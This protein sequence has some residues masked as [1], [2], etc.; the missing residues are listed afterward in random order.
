M[1]G[2]RDQH[3]GCVG[4][5]LVE[6]DLFDFLLLSL[7]DN[8]T[9]SHKHGPHAQVTSIADADR[10]LERVMH[11]GGGP[12][13]FLDE[14]AV[15]VVADHSH[16]PVERASRP[17]RRV[18]RL[19]GAAGPRPARAPTT[20]RSRVC[21]SQRAAMVYV[22]VPERARRSVLPRLRRRRRSTLEGVDLVMRRERATR[23]SSRA[24]RGE[25][26][27]APGRA[28]CATR[29]AGAGSSRGDL[30][31]CSTRRSR[32]ACFAA[33]TYP[34]ALARVWAALSCPTS[35]DVLLSA[36]P[37]YEFPDWGGAD[38]VGGGSHGSLHRSRLARARS[39][40]CGVEPPASATPTAQWSIARRR[41]DGARALRGVP[42]RGMT[43]RGSPAPCRRAARASA[44]GCTPACA[45]PRNWLAARALRRRRRER[46]RRQPRRL[47]AAR[48]RR[49][50]SDYR[51]A[52][53]G[54]FVVAVTNNF[55]WNRHWTFAR[56]TGTPASR[57]RA[58]SSS[59]LVAFAF[60][61][62]VLELLVAGLG[63]RRGPG[64]G[65]GD[66]R[67]DAA[68]LPRQQALELR[69]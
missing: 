52:A 43:R 64:A 34:D 7:P 67:R 2:M 31:R 57:P 38:H 14:H 19:R 53:T 54:A 20:P 62:V 41:A 63:V 66:R 39:L 61:L 40:F 65:D 4:A 17:H 11:A 50:A 44:R 47:R 48:A 37:G 56:A 10:Q 27:F 58:S 13:A 51:L 28:R 29:A 12:D 6:H 60:N 68:E 3:A 25:L 5:Y 36:A 8:D 42:S 26:R 15:I 32:T 22:L 49:S 23:A 30:E 1:P 55:V 45:S 69:P 9:H 21:P 46:L 33:T 18:R 59:A 16:A 35:G 24:A